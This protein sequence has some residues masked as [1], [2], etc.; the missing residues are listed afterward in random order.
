MASDLRVLLV[1]NY[2]SAG[3]ASRSISEEL[4][5][6]LPALGCSVVTTSSKPGRLGRV[7][8]MVRTAWTRRLDFDI[9][10]VDV[11]SGAAFFWAE[12]VCATL[13]VARKPYILTLHG[14]S[15]PEFAVRH[16]G[17][18]RRLFRHAAAV[19]TPSGYLLQELSPLR[20]D[21]RLIPNG[22]DV[23]RYEPRRDT[24]ARRHLIWLRAFHRVYNPVLAV[25]VLSKVLP[26]FPDVRLT[27]VGADKKDG[28]LKEASARA[29]S[30]GVSPRVQ[31][32]PPVPKLE[33]PRTLA[34]GDI[35]LNTTNVD[36]A[37]V[38]V[39]EAMA[40]EL[41]VVSTNVGG[42]PHVVTGDREGLLVPPRNPDAM[43]DAVKQLLR[44]PP[45]ASALAR[46]G[47][48]RAE[49]HDWSPI[50]STWRSL[51]AETLQRR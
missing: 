22:I 13:R 29:R 44:D 48:A 18:T 3:G 36:S 49:R 14:G 1:G 7:T 35:F 30:L 16:P 17:R 25:D 9:A 2:L 40:S 47:R 43:A 27:M 42:V 41:C 50:V 24:H 6:R 51:L 45:R 33:V 26:E 20:E 21:I 28:S 15:L 38:T 11:F 39:L 23:A 4:A 5:S 37:P 12:A 19:T 34:A 31:F 46:S 10:Q 8:D 32:C